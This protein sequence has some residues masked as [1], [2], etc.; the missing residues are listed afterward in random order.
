MVVEAAPERVAEDEVARQA[1][2]LGVPDPRAQV[3]GALSAVHEVFGLGAE[4]LCV[5]TVGALGQLS[6]RTRSEKARARA[7]EGS[8]TSI[9]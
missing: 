3:E 6:R 7:G 9:W 5:E 2:A 8:K 1:L 4:P